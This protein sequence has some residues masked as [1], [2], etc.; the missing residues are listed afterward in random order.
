MDNNILA[1]SKLEKIVND[2][3]TLGYGKGQ[4]TNEFPLKERV[5]W[6]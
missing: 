4:Q 5:E 2:L 1:S 3:L 6:G